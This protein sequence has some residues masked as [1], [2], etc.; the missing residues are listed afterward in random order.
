MSEH[1]PMTGAEL[2][3]ARRWWEAL[4]LEVRQSLKLDPTAAVDVSQLEHTVSATQATGAVWTS[5]RD[6]VDGFYLSER[7]AEFVVDQDA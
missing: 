7:I 2:D 3:D 6:G 5:T 4:P 1:E